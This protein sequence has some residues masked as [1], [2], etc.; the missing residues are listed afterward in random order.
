MDN[1]IEE[2]KVRAQER[3]DNFDTE[4]LRDGK[5][6]T[7]SEERDGNTLNNLDKTYQKSS[8]ANKK[9]KIQKTK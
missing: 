6:S 1:E 2:Q 5:V 9:T 8:N 4:L 3:Y 7:E